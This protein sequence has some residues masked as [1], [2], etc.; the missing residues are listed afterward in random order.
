MDLSDSFALRTNGESCFR[1]VGMNTDRPVLH[2]FGQAG[3][4]AG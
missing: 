4:G 3:T 2:L 1:E